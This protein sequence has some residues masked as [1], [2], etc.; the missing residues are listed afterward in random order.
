M[1]RQARK[2]ATTGNTAQPSAKEVSDIAGSWE[3]GRVALN[4]FF[5]TV[6]EG[7]ASKRLVMIPPKG[8]GYSRSKTLYTQLQKDAAL[9][10]NRGGEAL[11]GIWGQLM[12]YG[13]VPT[14]QPCGNSAQA[15]Y[16]Q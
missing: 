10:R 12:V 4:S 3:A 6:N 5:T 2:G 8:Q 11:A 15:Y 7:T 14:V 13:T 16:S 9:C 1:S